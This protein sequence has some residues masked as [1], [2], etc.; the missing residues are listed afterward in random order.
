MALD[1]MAAREQVLTAPVMRLLEVL[2]PPGEETRVVGG[3]VRNALLGRRIEDFDLATSLEPLQTVQRAQA[4]GWRVVPTGL[5]HGTVTV[6]IAGQPY[7]VTTL[8]EDIATNGRHAEVRFGGDFRQDAARRDFTINAMSMGLDG[9]LSD[10]FGGLEDLEARVVRFIGDA[11]QRLRED[12][13]RGLR[14]LRFSATYAAGPLDAE[15]LRAV[16]AE[17]AG[18]AQ[19]SRERVRQEFFKLL[20]AA[21]VLD[22]LAEAQS[23]GL[24]SAVLGL[25][26]D[27]GRLGA[28]IA[29]GEADAIAR[30]FALCVRE[31]GDVSHL[32]Q[33]LR[34]SNHEHSALAQLDAATTRFAG[35]AP[36]AMRAL[37]ADFPA[38]A[39]DAVLH[40]SLDAG[41]GFAARALDA[42][43]PMPVFGLTGKDA[44]ALGLEPGPRVGAALGKARMIWI[45]RGSQNS[46]D[47]QLECLKMAVAED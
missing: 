27:V 18:F 44:M 29:A 28:R 43:A 39:H 23:A 12:Y 34:L 35:Q 17:Q 4:A 5:D 19:L 8:R 3:A 11:H 16:I 2:S 15:G 33:A 37:A 45:G 7:E 31:R 40:L 14:F 25:R 22:V 9:V 46:R 36:E 41:P 38:V 6:L 20:M 10:Y 42:M 32:R 24:I 26:V 30:L 47:A 13:L 1:V 21:R